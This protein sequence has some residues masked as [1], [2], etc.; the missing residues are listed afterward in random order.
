MASGGS[1]SATVA[2]STRR[3]IADFIF[4]VADSGGETTVGSHVGVAEQAETRFEV[5][6]FGEHL[7]L[8][9]SGADNLTRDGDEH[10]VFARGENINLCNLRFLVKLLRSKL[11]RFA[12]PMVLGF[13]QRGLE[14]HLPQQIRVVEILR[15]AFKESD[16]GQ[17]RL[18]RVQILRLRKL[19]QRAD[20]I[21]LRRV[22][23]DDALTLLELLNDV[24][25]VERGQHRHDN[26]HEKP[27]PRQA[28]S[29][30]E[31]LC[32]VET[33][34]S[35]AGGGRTVAGRCLARIEF[36]GFHKMSVIVAFA[37]GDEF[38]DGLVASD[39][40]ARPPTSGARRQ[41]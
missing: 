40:V 28:V 38:A 29:L 15:V 26:G 12:R 13:L 35:N 4:E 30:R 41:T 34:A 5:E 1:A 20:V 3:L 17:F 19:K 18:L 16:C 2:A 21:G 22:N 23:D 25:A 7:F 9:D 37:L 33:L 31:K 39:V 36:G 27:E 32:W 10:L 14:K 6:G 8:E 24:V 11:D